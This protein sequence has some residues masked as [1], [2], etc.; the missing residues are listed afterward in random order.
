MITPKDEI[1]QALR[2]KKRLLLVSCC[3]FFCGLLDDNLIKKIQKVSTVRPG[4]R[5]ARFKNK[6]FG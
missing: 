4:I 1:T 6:L 3:Y 2:I 5:S